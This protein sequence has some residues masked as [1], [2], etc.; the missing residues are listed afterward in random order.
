MTW[1]NPALLEAA[2]PEALA[3]LSA[4][5]H[6]RPVAGGVIVRIQD[7]P[8]VPGEAWTRRRQAADEAFGLAELHRRFPRVV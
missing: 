7:E 2:G 1:L 5:C 8:S 3:R 4:L 6:V